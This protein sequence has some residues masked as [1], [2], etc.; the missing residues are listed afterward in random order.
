MAEKGH[1]HNET[2]HTQDAAKQLPFCGCFG[3]SP[4]TNDLPSR[5]RSA[6]AKQ[7]AQKSA[8]VEPDE[9]WRIGSQVPEPVE[10]QPSTAL[11]PVSRDVTPRSAALSASHELMLESTE[12]I[13]RYPSGL[14]VKARHRG[15]M[16]P[17]YKVAEEVSRG[18]VN[19]TLEQ[20]DEESRPP[21]VAPEVVRGRV[22][23]ATEL[24]HKQLSQQEAQHQAAHL[25]REL[26]NL[27]GQN[28]KERLAVPLLR[29]AGAVQAALTWQHKVGQYSVESRAEVQQHHSPLATAVVRL[30]KEKAVLQAQAS[31][32]STQM[33]AGISEQQQ[34]QLQQQQQESG[35]RVVDGQL[36]L[37]AQSEPVTSSTGDH[38]SQGNPAAWDKQAQQ[39]QQAQRE[40]PQNVEA[41]FHGAPT[42]PETAVL[43]AA[44]ADADNK[45]QT[46]QAEIT[47]DDVEK[48]QAEVHGTQPAPDGNVS[49]EHAHSERESGSRDFVNQTCL[50]HQTADEEITLRPLDKTASHTE[51]KQRGLVESRRPSFMRPTASSIAHNVS[52]LPKGLNKSLSTSVV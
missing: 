26:A 12:T 37:Q 38:A 47:Q 4:Y 19:L 18:D 29:L 43:P 25:S 44:V 6:P 13:R 41:C 28:Q 40:A 3:S 52:T 2:L 24:W 21:V 50:L 27:Q 7:S 31:G 8:A 9:A 22:V 5:P 36:V 14:S 51:P 42:Q 32:I 10:N 46:A 16:G 34:Q 15:G 49:H 11:L 33:P 17:G 39:A 35:T 20:P 48:P 23:R 1:R 45:S 30:E